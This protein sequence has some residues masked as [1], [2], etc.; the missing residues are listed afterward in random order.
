MLAVILFAFFLAVLVGVIVAVITREF[1]GFLVGFWF[2]LV[3][4][5]WIGVIYVGAHFVG[6]YW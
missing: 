6:K 3:I 1:G 2:A 4:Q 5:F